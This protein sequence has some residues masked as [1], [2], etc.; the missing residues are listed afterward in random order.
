MTF[1]FNNWLTKKAQSHNFGSMT[2]ICGSNCTGKT[3]LL[4]Q[5]LNSDKTGSTFLFKG[6]NSLGSYFIHTPYNCDEGLEWVVPNNYQ[7]TATWFDTYAKVFPGDKLYDSGEGILIG[8]AWGNKYKPYELSSAKRQVMQLIAWLSSPR[9]AST[10]L[11]DD[12]GSLLH[13]DSQLA[14]LK[15]LSDNFSHKHRFILA[16]HSV[17]VGGQFSDKDK[18]FLDS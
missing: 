16:S 3:N 1:N 11:I 18:I 12:F 6:Q 17:F 15:C 7:T 10:I 2:L 13:P 14:L 5:I 8:D 9:E 4:N